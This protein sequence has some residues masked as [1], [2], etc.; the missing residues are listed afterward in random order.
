M[1]IF[2]LT[3][4]MVLLTIGSL[5]AQRTIT[6]TVSDANTGEPLIGANILVLGSSTGTITDIDGN[7]SLNVPN[8]TENLEISYTGFTAQQVSIAGGIS[9]LTV[10]LESGQL[11]EEVVVIGYTPVARKKVLGAL[12]SVDAE[13]IVKNTPVGAFDAVQGRLSG[14]QILTNGGPGAGYDIRI[15]GVST[16]SSGTQP[17]FV[18][19]GQQLEN[20][21]NIDPND[22]LSF[23]VLKDGATAAIY[24][25]RGANGVVLITTKNGRS[26]AV[27]IDVTANTSF[28]NLNGAIPLAN[29]RQRIFY[30]DIRRNNSG[31][32][33][34]V[35]RDS[36]SLLNRNSHDLQ[37]LL[38]RTAIRH[39]VNVA[40]SG[41]SDKAKVYWNTGFQDQEGV[42]VN[43]S[44]QRI[45][46]RL[47]LAFT[48]V[49]RFSIGT[50]LN[51]SYEDR[52]G[53][54]EGQVF[55]QMVER[56]AY[57]P[58]FE[59]NGTF[60]P[61]IAGRQN[62]IAE[63]N[64][65]TLRDRNYRAQ[66]FNH[67]EFKILPTLSLKSTLG[68][69]FRYRKN[70]D[71]EP[72]LTQNPRSP[73]PRGAERRN[74]AYDLQQENFINYIQDFGKHSFSAFAGI[75]TQ[76]YYSE[77]FNIRA[78]FVSDAIQTFNNI[79]PLTLS[80]TNGTIN[81]RHNLVSQFG[82]FN[83]DF[84]NKYLLGAT[85][86]RDGSSRFGDENEYGIFPSFTLGWRL[87][88]EG[89]IQKALPAVDNF[90]LRFSYGETG[91]ERIGNY[92]FTSTY[93]PGFTYNGISGVAPARLGNPAISWES[94]S[95][96][97]LGFDLG[98]FKNRLNITFE[99]W[100]K[101]TNDLLASVPLP[102]E[103]GFAS[104]RKNVGSVENRGLDVGINGVLVKTR[105]FTWESS[106]NL[107]FLENEVTQLADGTPFQS[108]DYLIEEGQPLGNIFGFKNLGIYQYDESNAYTDDGVLLT[109]NFTEEG[110]FLNYTLN[111]TEYTGTV[112]RLR[113]A[114]RV[115]EGGDIIWE[116][117]NGDFDITVADKQVIGNGLPTLF[118]GFTNDFNYK[119]LS[120]SFLFDFT[121]G[122]DIWRRYDETRNDL[123]SSN[124]TPGPD[125]IEGAWQ[126]PGDVT[127]YPRL[128]RVPQNRERPNSFF[129]TKG[130]FIKLR[131][132]RLSYAL[133][134]K[135]LNR[136]GF[137]KRL[138]FNLSFNDFAT[139]TNYLGY[140][141]ELGS[142]G[143]PLQPGR[144]DL[145]YPNSRSVITG[146]RVQF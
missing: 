142:R 58:I 84:N 122:N 12:A 91:N 52:F 109:A 32:L 21:D 49:Q 132:V 110:D 128:N 35:Q 7:F 34:G 55:Q 121:F 16:F 24:G 98:M 1:K 103:S 66:M 54:N 139:W 44:Y 51:V 60:T 119:G 6:G 112:K 28:T 65:R 104:I 79:D 113:N 36:L 85:V 130:D 87:S 53:L 124:E 25:S 17:L 101:E 129:V 22:I 30:E 82:G 146:L 78:N 71:F 86:R 43:S 13:D 20:I 5:M 76:R 56:I 46:S 137:I 134:K 90:L 68:L 102:E 48:P 8:D 126:N 18:V 115:L 59:P 10:A 4:S 99:V 96:T 47:K 105:D 89:F 131:F 81:E 106:F 64:L 42:V 125:R 2:T 72:I 83:Y 143:N 41:G 57:F 40:V 145:R 88:N 75:Q 31:P 62:P 26:D 15:R 123:N 74:L 14:V 138:S 3:L 133:P 69:N 97:N 117:L 63:A 116:D 50:N 136:L 144:D 39:Q 38:T 118:G 107:S 73:I 23:E 100:R 45:N 140:N 92:E 67:A 114:G 11:L 70:N 80:I 61:E 95:S 93:L 27:N 33:T 37:D 19:D 111:G 135:V 9:N 94:T 141:P 108:G 77:G 120:L 127:E 29:T